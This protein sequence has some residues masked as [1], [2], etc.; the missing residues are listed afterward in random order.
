MNKIGGM[1]TMCGGVLLISLLAGCAEAP[2]EKAAKAA[3]EVFIAQSK[4]AEQFANNE[5][6]DARNSLDKAMGVI[7]MEDKKVALFRNYK[8][9][10]LEL[11]K[12]IT[13][14]KDAARKAEENEKIAIEKQKMAQAEALKK[15]K[16]TTKA[17]KKKTGTK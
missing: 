7:R 17:A 4:N 2:K 9:A 10:E 15:P 16:V 13:F 8:P 6:N 5:Y 14:A 12:A 3:Y 11:D 1:K